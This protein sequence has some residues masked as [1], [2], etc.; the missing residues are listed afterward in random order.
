MS[1]K[2]DD[3][4]SSWGVRDDP[5]GNDCII[6]KGLLC[7]LVLMA[8]GPK[9]CDELTYLARNPDVADAVSKGAFMTGRHHYLWVGI[10]EGRQVGERAFE[11][12]AY[13][14]ANPD[15]K[16]EVDEGGI[17]SGK[18]HWES[19]GWLEGRST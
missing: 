12:I 13:L 8:F 18:A 16:K 14:L 2:I 17:E 7:R 10:V 11:E 5:N 3:L 4:L 19:H 1:V 6:P 15:V 9:F